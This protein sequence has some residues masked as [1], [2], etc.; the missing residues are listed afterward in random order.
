MADGFLLAIES[1][2]S[3]ASVAVGRKGELVAEV[4]GETGRRQSEALMDPLRQVLAELE[5]S[6]IEGVL[7]GTG[8]G[9]YNGVRVGIATGQGVALVHGC[10]A[11]GVCSLEAL[12][13]VRAGGDC[14]A[15]GD[16]RRGT[17]FTLALR[18]GKLSG[19]PEL[20]EAGD[21][22]QGVRRA[23]E[24][25]VSLVT[26]EEVDRLGLPVDLAARVEHAAPSAGRLLEAWSS[27]SA[28]ER[29]VLL[30]APPQPF[31][32]REAYITVAKGK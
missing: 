15:L 11:V 13:T 20:L 6:G 4:E 12:R 23:A 27:K 26:V 5:G 22:Q 25:G 18:E 14:L 30:E 19:K 8:P 9:S 2:A 3:R 1:S 31:Y 7:I 16:A 28:G 24:E 29:Q 10:P 17:F 32:L 21:F